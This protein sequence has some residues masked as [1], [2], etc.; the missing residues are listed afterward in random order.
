MEQSFRI[1]VLPD[2]GTEFVLDEPDLSFIRID[3]RLKLQFG[4][5]QLAIDRHFAVSG[6]SHA[7][8]PRRRDQLGPAIALFPATLRWL[9]T[10]VGGDLTAIFMSG[11]K[12]AVAH[13][14]TAQAW[15]ISSL[16]Y[17][18]AVG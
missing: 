5:T 3:D 15:S 12:L 7:L 9:W 18:D 1:R 4:F 13:D 6:S 14:P 11:V 17:P 16:R 8:D 2:G 10:S